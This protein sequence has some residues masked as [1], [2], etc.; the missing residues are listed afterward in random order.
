MYFNLVWQCCKMSP[1]KTG[2]E[3]DNIRRRLWNS[4][5]FIHNIF[6]HHP[7]FIQTLIEDK[8]QCQ[9]HANQY[10]VL[11]DPAYLAGL[12]FCVNTGKNMLTGMQAKVKLC[13][14]RLLVSQRTQTLISWVKVLFDPSTTPSSS[15]FLLFISQLAFISLWNH[16]VLKLQRKRKLNAD[17]DA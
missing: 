7:P 8:Y 10:Q 1:G 4:W 15:I 2:R 16:Q 17:N 6:M 14:C 11:G 12:R 5:S 13:N 3:R 9:K